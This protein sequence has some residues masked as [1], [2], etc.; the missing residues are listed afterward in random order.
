MFNSV[1]LYITWKVHTACYLNIIVKGGGLLKCTGSHV[2]WK[3]DVLE[4]VLGYCN[5]RPL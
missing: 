3:S 4:T 5:K 2:H 1:C